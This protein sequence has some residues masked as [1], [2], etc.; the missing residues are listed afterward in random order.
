ME[1]ARTANRRHRVCSADVSCRAR[2][3]EFTLIDTEVAEHNLIHDPCGRQPSPNPALIN[4]EI[5]LVGQ[6]DAAFGSN[7]TVP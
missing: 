5:R 3:I 2:P 4:R 1:R 7:V 6:Y